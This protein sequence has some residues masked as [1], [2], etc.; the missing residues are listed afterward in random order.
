MFQH[1]TLR[2]KQVEAVSVL[3]L[4]VVANQINLHI[5]VDCFA[6]KNKKP[7]RCSEADGFKLQNTAQVGLGDLGN[8]STLITRATPPDQRGLR[9][10]VLSL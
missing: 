10:I 5:I 3:T 2:N 6:I 9:V 1:C 4:R 8:L 7:S